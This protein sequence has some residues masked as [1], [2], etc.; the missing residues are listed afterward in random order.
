MRNLRR[1]SLVSSIL[2]L[3][4]AATLSCSNDDN[5]TKPVPTGA[6]VT[7]NIVGNNGSNS[8]SPNPDTVT[9]GQTVAWKNND[10]M[11][12]TATAN[13]ASFNT[14]DVTAGSTSA[15]I[16]MNTVGSFPYH[17]G[18]HPSMVGTL[19]V[20]AAP[21]P[22]VT[23]SIVGNSGSN[24]YSPDPDTVS[25][26]QAVR[27]KNNDSMNHTATSDNGTTFDTGILGPGATSAPDTMLTAGSF[28]Y[29]CDLH[30]GMVG[31]LVVKP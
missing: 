17:C 31:T 1:F 19:V 23:I 18:I 11:T 26:G 22:T 28:P 2:P 10:T 24:S 27:W 25:I 21:L 3:A 13:G 7:I 6:D 9:A 4:F 20:K 12:H 8:Y 14:G 29:H 16:A 5:P 15:A 30:V